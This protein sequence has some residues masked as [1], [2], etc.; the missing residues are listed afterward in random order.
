MVLVVVLLVVVVVVG[1][2]VVVAW[3]NF[4]G[5]LGHRFLFVGILRFSWSTSVPYWVRQFLTCMFVQKTQ[6][7]NYK[8]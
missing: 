3:L 7:S 8:M 6:K 1:G 4:S 2:G 5:L